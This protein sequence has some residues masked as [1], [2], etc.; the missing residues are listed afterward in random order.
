[1]ASKLKRS[2]WPRAQRETIGWSVALGVIR[3]LPEAY[4]LETV[5]GEH[6]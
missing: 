5:W 4:I 6:E 1:M 3:W 2:Q